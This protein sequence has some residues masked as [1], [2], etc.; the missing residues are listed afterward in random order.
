V[1]LPADL[2]ERYD[3][4][5][6]TEAYHHVAGRPTY[7]L[8]R[9]GDT[10]YVKV[11]PVGSERELI[12]EAARLRWAADLL[13]VP[14]IVEQGNDGEVCWLMTAGLPGVAAHSHPWRASAPENLAGAL[15]AGL[16]WLHDSVPAFECPFPLVAAEGPDEVVLHG[17]FSLPNVLLIDGAVSGL[18]DVG[19]LGA[20]D[21][22]WDVAVGLKSLAYNC[23]P[24]YEEAFL[25]A[26]G[27][28]PAHDRIS[29]HRAT[30]DALP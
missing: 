2:A 11:L 30:Y 7:R 23:G 8:S 3:G 20:G 18:L 28:P 24:G 6:V 15:G 29:A 17:D 12:D 13:P 4:W 19:G 22:W 26:Y 21:R 27:L 25:T 16:R 14:R 9:D 1:S 5:Q 10:R